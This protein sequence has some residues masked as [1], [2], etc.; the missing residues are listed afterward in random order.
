[1]E[2]GRKRGREV[3]KERWKRGKSKEGGMGGRREEWEEEGRNEKDRGKTQTKMK[4]KG[5]K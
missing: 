3:C 5:K 2:E 4:R 1:M